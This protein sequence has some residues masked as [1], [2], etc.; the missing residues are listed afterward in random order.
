[1]RRA[2]EKGRVELFVWLARRNFLVPVPQVQS[3]VALNQQVTGPL[4][5]PA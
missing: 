1:M 3:L 5:L 2:N 4:N